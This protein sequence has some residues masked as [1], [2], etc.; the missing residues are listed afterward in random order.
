MHVVFIRS[1]RNTKDLHKR[2]FPSAVEKAI[3]SSKV[4][5]SHA[6]FVRGGCQIEANQYAEGERNTADMKSV[7]VSEFING[8]VYDE[9]C[10]PPSTHNIC[11]I[12]FIQYNQIRYKIKNLL[13]CLGCEGKHWLPLMVLY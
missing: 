2:E 1:C 7:Y 11:K 12:K 13:S 3:L 5:V 6:L 8:G 9:T 4:I 10:N